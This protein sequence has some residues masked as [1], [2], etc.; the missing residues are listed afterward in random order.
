V[1]RAGRLLGLGAYTE[2]RRYIGSDTPVLDAAGGFVVPAFHD[3]HVHLLTLA[4]TSSAL[5]CGASASIAEI[6]AAIGARAA[7]A[8][9]GTWIRAFGYDHAQMEEQR[10]PTRFDLDAIAPEHPVRLQHRALHLDILN[11]LALQL[12][13][14]LGSSSS[15][16]E[17]DETGQPTGRLWH[18]GDL[19]H[20]HLPRLNPQSLQV[21]VA[22]TSARLLQNGVTTVQD[23]SITSG[24]EEWELFHTLAASGSLRVRLFAMT[25]AHK[26]FD[27][28]SARPPSSAIRLGHVKVMIDES[29][30][31][32]AEVRSLVAVAR[33]AG[34]PVA[35]H[36]V[37]EAELAIALD[38]LRA[39]P[40][41]PSSWAPDRIEHAGVV[42]D[43]MLTELRAARVTVVGQP[44]L[45]HLQGDRYHDE[46]PSE[47]HAWLHRIGSFIAAGIPY[48]ASSDAPVT[49]A[50]P[51]LT[52]FSARRRVTLSGWTLGAMERVG[53]LQA[54]A[55]VTSAPARAGGTWPELGVLREGAIADIVVL[56]PEALSL[57]AETHK[58]PVRM[59]IKDGRLAW[60]R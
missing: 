51:Q 41:P 24:V 5:D 17:R 50:D 55:A 3:A 39:H 53:P 10:H 40:R 56:D 42:P 4:R 28:A 27:S 60:R 34:R 26:L 47:Q 18:A 43:P 59:T 54:L 36:A 12:C 14:L 15:L 7:V 31:D 25:G 35:L 19:L 38:A 20:D 52:M 8:A 9:R 2:L 48:V 46:F 6:T 37:T 13:G 45:I 23:A 44:A 30:S 21:D 32:P 58:R 29:S 49:P 33:R 1:T 11:T 57:R 22:A 16:I